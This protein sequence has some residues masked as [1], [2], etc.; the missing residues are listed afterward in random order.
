MLV[1]GIFHI[2]LNNVNY[3]TK[4]LFMSHYAFKKN[5]VEI[6]AFGA[7][8]DDSLYPRKQEVSSKLVSFRGDHE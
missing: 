8:S 3:H 2:F 5:V 6:I 7:K 4:H 1:L